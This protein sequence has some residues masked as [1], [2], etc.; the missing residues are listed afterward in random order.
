[1]RLVRIAVVLGGMMALGGCQTLKDV[2]YVQASKAAD[3]GHPED[4]FESFKSLA[5]AD[6][7]DGQ[8]SSQYRVGQMY[9]NGEGTARKPEAALRMFERAAASPDRSWRRMANYQ[10]GMMYLEGVK[11]GV[12]RNRGEAAIYFQRSARDGYDLAQKRLEKLAAYPE[13]VVILHP[14]EFLN[15]GNNPAPGKYEQAVAYL[16]AGDDASAFPILLWYAREGHGPS[17]AMVGVIYAQGKVVPQNL[18]YFMAWTLLAAF[19]DDVE[20]QLFMAESYLAGKYVPF[21]EEQAR[22]LFWRASENGRPDGRAMLGYLMIFPKEKGRQPD[23]QAGLDFIRQSVAKGSPKGMRMLGD[24]YTQGGWGLAKD[25]V[26]GRAYYEKAAA[27][28][29]VEARE[30]LARNGASPAKGATVAAAPGSSSVTGAAEP[31][32]AAGGSVPAKPTAV[33]LFARLSPSVFRLLA[34]EAKGSGAASGSAVAVT[35]R[36]AA[37]NCHVLEGLDV[38]GAKLDGDIVMFQRSHSNRA[39]DICII[40][41]SKSLKP[42]AQYRQYSALKVGERVYAIGSPASL[43]NTISEGIISGLRTMG[44][45]RYVQISAPIAPG[46]SGG[47]LFDEEGRLIGITTKGIERGDL[48]FA[49]AVDEVFDGLKPTR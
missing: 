46:S 11:D 12:D 3:A 9:L 19:S 28:G 44:G 48:N 36:L 5:E 42:V 41:A 13:V 47:G 7:Y 4:A 40:Q 45:V 33:E 35:E 38:Y 24:A 23:I 22:L 2:N 15:S 20:S 29:D 8:A 31:P 37:T 21:D 27:K 49:V 43:E 6:G 30:A 25:P 32:V 34:L 18:K 16:K 10:I 39:K 1:M 26:Q 14:E 17:Q